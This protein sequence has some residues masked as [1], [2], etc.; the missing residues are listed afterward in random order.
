MTYTDSST[1]IAIIKY[2]L[3]G[4]PEEARLQRGTIQLVMVVQL[5]KKEWEPLAPTSKEF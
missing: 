4:M 1:S 5:H 2:H 3:Q